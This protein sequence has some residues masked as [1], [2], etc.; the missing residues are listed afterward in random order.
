[1]GLGRSREILTH[2]D[3]STVK[4]YETL[5]PVSLPS[6]KILLDFKMAKIWRSEKRF[7]SHNVSSGLL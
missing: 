6:T 2:V 3:Y 5:S 4:I 7:L 1:M